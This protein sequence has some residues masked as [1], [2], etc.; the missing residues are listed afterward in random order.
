MNWI[1]EAVTMSN[2]KS[3]LKQPGKF[4]KV[5]REIDQLKFAVSTILLTLYF[6]CGSEVTVEEFVCKI[7]VHSVNWSL[8]L[9]FIYPSIEYRKRYDLMLT[10]P[11]G[12][13]T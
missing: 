8:F 13:G 10:V 5:Q 1:E 6:I 2:N 11:K 7:A 9:T 4:T 12:R 3:S